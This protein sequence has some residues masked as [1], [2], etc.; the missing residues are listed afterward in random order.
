MNTRPKQDISNKPFSLY[1]RAEYYH[2][3]AS[4]VAKTKK[5]DHI[6]VAT[7]SFMPEEPPIQRIMLELCSA[8]RRGVNI[9][10]LVDAFPFLLGEGAA[11]GPLLFTRQLPRYMPRV[12][13]A[14]LAALR[15]L[16]AHGGKFA[17][18]N[19]PGQRFSNPFAGRSHIKFAVV[20][21]F[22][23]VGGCNLTKVNHLD[24]MVGWHDA[25]TASR[26]HTFAHNVAESG[27]VRKTLGTQD[28]NISVNPTTSLLIDVGI[29]GQSLI[30]DTALSLIDTA[31]EGIFITCQYFPNNVTARQ[32]AAAQERG[33]AVQIVYNHPSKHPMPLNLLHHAVL[34]TEKHRKQRGLF[35]YQLPRKHDFLHA[36]VLV[37]DQGCMIGSHNYVR[38]GVKF[39]TAEVALLSHDR[40]F[41]DKLIEAVCSQLCG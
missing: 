3:L 14:R 16:E 1:T 40:Q 4:M 13:R 24:L 17:I 6:S 37:T 25:T 5:G 2:E 35:D 22:I 41:G 27:S 7:M 31:Q 26:L 8:A 15:N 10:L 32:L 11:P 30:M 18:V 38:A 12:F 9:T 19:W 21:N 34:L 33:V 29:P 28:V 20:N 39:G 23:F 36:K